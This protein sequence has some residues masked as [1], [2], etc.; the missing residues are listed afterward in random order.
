MFIFRPRTLTDTGSGN[1]INDKIRFANKIKTVERQIKP[2]RMERVLTELVQFCSTIS[3]LTEL[4]QFCRTI[5]VLTGLV[6]FSGI[7]SVLTELV[8]F[9]RT[10][11]VFDRACSVL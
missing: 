10:I 7:I 3:V 9:C 2:I 8:Q 1:K 11:N 6:Q 5:G 4:V